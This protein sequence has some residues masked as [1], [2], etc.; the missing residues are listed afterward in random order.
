MSTK[1]T[2]VFY[3]FVLVAAIVVA[4]FVLD[5][6]MGAAAQLQNGLHVAGF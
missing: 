4:H 2:F 6:G 5:A 1:M 3:A